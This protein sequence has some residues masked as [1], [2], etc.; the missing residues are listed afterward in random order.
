MTPYLKTDSVTLYHGEC[1]EV[2]AGLRDIGLSVDLVLTDPPY[3][4][5]KD[6]AWDRINH[7][8]LLDLLDSVFRGVIPLMKFNASLYCFCW[9]NFSD[10]ISMLVR[11][12]FAFLGSI[13]WCK[14]RPDGKL[15]GMACKASLNA[16]RLPFS[17]TERIVFAEMKN[18]DNVAD[19]E[20]HYSTRCENTYHH[21][22][23]PLIDYFIQAKKESG[24]SNHEICDRMA[25]LTGKRYVFAQHSFGHSQ[26]ELPTREQYEAAQTFMKIVKSG[27]FIGLR[28]E[29]E[30]LRR[31]YENLRREYRP[32]RENFTD[33]WFY[34]PVATGAKERIHNCQKPILMLR[35]MIETSCRP[36][37]LVLDP[38]SGSGS[39]AIAALQTGRRAVLIER[40][41]RNCEKAAL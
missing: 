31:E 26:W 24:F 21:T 16:V 25:A 41:E 34:Q 1:R 33:L 32:K 10:R 19:G 36:G 2:L 14:R 22:M 13:V 15:N 4:R 27:E 29:Y 18:S 3:S 37:G 20:A 5:V 39:T 9:P 17:E 30:N 38:F 6:D 7:S 8:S 11:E 28:R 23:Q 40:D 12:H 35:D